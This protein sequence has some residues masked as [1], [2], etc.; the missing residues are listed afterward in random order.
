MEHSIP[1]VTTNPTDYGTLIRLLP[2]R[3]EQRGTCHSWRKRYGK[4]R[5]FPAGWK[6]YRVG[7]GYGATTADGQEIMHWHRVQ[8]PLI[9]AWSEQEVPQLEA[10]Q[11]GEQPAILIRS[12]SPAFTQL[13]LRV[14]EAYYVVGG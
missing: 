14:G 10:I 7:E 2:T 8:H 4:Q 11:L 3:N 1:R 6:L 9:Y 12:S 5:N 13:F